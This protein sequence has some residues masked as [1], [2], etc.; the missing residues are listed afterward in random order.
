MTIRDLEIIRT[1]RRYVNKLRYTQDTIGSRF[2]N[3]ECIFDAVQELEDGFLSPD[4]FPTI[5]VFWDE[6]HRAWFSLNNRRLWCFKNAK[7]V[8]QVWVDVIEKS[9]I[10]GKVRKRCFTTYNNGMDVDVMYR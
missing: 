9:S 3:G 8:Q 2:K 10:P 6:D 1:E 7:G 4:D 5:A